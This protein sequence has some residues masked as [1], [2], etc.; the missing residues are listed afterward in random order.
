MKY[1]RNIFGLQTHSPCQKPR[2]PSNRR[3][4]AGCLQFSSRKN[5]GCAAA[6]HAMHRIFKSNETEGILLADTKNA[7][8]SI[9]QKAL[10]HNIKYLH[11]IVEKFLYNCYA[12]SARLFITGKKIKIVQKNNRGEPNSDGSVYIRFNSITLSF[13]IH[14]KIFVKKHSNKIMKFLLIVYFHGTMNY[15]IIFFFLSIYIVRIFMRILM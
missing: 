2:I 14:C 12:I 11:P 3:K 4:A 8:N 13:P 9:K 7:F 10:P 1:T 15:K 5:A 6:I